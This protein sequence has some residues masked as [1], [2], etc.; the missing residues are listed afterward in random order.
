[1]RS[2]LRKDKCPAQRTH[3]HNSTPSP[4][5]S[6]VC[7]RGPPKL[8]RISSNGSVLLSTGLAPNR[9]HSGRKYILSNIFN[10]LGQKKKRN[11]CSFCISRK[12]M[13]SLQ[14]LGQIP[15]SSFPVLKVDEVA[16]EHLPWCL[17][18]G[19]RHPPPP[20]VNRIRVCILHWHL[21][22]SPSL[23]SPL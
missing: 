3:P 22:N 18:H 11:I 23:D 9:Y 6:T 16:I 1:M 5:H 7:L 15:H 8:N 10:P 19:H 2:K 12:F 20:A 4:Y 13:N 17:L 21:A 14:F